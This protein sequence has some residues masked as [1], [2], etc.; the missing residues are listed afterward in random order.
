MD[1]GPVPLILFYHIQ[2]YEVGLATGLVDLR[3]QGIT[4][5]FVAARYKHGRALFRKQPGRRATHAAVTAGDQ[6]RSTRRS[7]WA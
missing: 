1:N 7:P 4:A 5:L 2:F 6:R 3:D